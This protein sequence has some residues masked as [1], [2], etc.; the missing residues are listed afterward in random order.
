MGVRRTPVRVRV[1]LPARVVL[2]QGRQVRVRR[3][4][5][6]PALSA[7]LVFG[8]PL[9]GMFCGLAMSLGLAPGFLDTPWSLAAAAFGL[10]LGGACACRLD[11]FFAKRRPPNV[12]SQ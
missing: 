6:N 5:P 3:F 11:Q 9:G 1:P 12:L 8:L 4:L 2:D 10:G 7:A